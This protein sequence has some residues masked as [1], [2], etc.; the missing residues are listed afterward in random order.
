MYYV[1]G[2]VYSLSIQFSGKHFP[3][4]G[5]QVG[6][7]PLKI[8]RQHIWTPILVLLQGMVGGQTFGHQG[9]PGTTTPTPVQQISNIAT[10]ITGE[11]YLLFQKDR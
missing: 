10:Y 2:L 5:E 11:T 6:F 3:T 4:L 9:Q 7:P 1:N 8:G